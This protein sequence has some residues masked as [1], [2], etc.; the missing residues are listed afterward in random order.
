MATDEQPM[1]WQNFLETRG[2][3][4]TGAN[5]K[6]PTATMVDRGELASLLAECPCAE[7][8]LKNTGNPRTTPTVPKER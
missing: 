5:S 7:E 1:A 3:R 2:S 8:Y 4:N 6:T